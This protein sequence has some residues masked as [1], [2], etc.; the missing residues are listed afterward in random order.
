[1][2]G[3]SRSRVE[4]RIA[5]DRD[6]LEAHFRVRHSVF[7]EEQSIFEITDRDRWDGLAVHLVAAQGRLVVG[8]VRLYPLDEAGL[9]QG[10]RLAVLSDARRSLLAGAPL[11]RAAVAEAGERGGHTMI[12]NIQERNVPFFLHLGWHRVGLL[13]PY[14]GL[15]HQRMAIPLSSAPPAFAEESYAWALGS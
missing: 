10:D 15:S 14:H 5:A 9:W 3:R 1:M 4:V 12:A 2:T 6:D 7:V 11:V 13:A 8:A